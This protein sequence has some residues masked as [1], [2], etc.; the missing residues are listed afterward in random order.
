ME[1]NQDQ[2]NLLPD[3]QTLLN[4]FNAYT[5]ALQHLVTNT[6]NPNV[7]YSINNLPLVTMTTAAAQSNNLQGEGNL[8]T[9][10]LLNMT[11]GQ[12]VKEAFAQTLINALTTSDAT[13][14]LNPIS[15]HS[16]MLASKDLLTIL[17]EPNRSQAPLQMKLPSFKLS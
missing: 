10:S 4:T 15:D 5:S 12:D 14:K 1:I 6:N 9:G 8:T 7:L 17:I 11:T 16:T 13:T 2:L 3:T